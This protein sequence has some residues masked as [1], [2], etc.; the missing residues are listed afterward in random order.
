MTICN[1]CVG[2]CRC[3]P[4]MTSPADTLAR[5][6]PTRARG[7]AKRLTPAQQAKQAAQI[8]ASSGEWDDATPAVLVGLYG[9]LHERHYGVWPAELDDKATW[10]AAVRAAQGLAFDHFQNNPVWAVEF[11]CWA[12]TR[13]RSRTRAPGWRLGWRLCFSAVF[14]TDYRVS[15]NGRT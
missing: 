5:A 13:E 8:R 1:E 11:I 6:I 7:Q 15:Q 12:W 4:G 9:L 3:N 2:P 14:V 10:Q